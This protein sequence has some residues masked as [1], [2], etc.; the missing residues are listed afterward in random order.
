MSQIDNQSHGARTLRPNL[1]TARTSFV[2]RERELAE[3]AELLETARLVTLTGPAGCG[4]TR[5]AL[6]LARRLSGRFASGVHWLA[7]DS[8]NDPDLLVQTLAKS[9]GVG[10]RPDQPIL[11][12]VLQALQDRPLLLVLDNC[13]HL[14]PACADLVERLL[15]DTP[16]TVLATSRQPVGIDGE[17]LYPVNPLP[18][19]PANAPVEELARNDAVR[20]FT[21]RAQAIRPDFNLNASNA[22][23]VGAICRAVDG[24][25]LAIEL[26]SARIN[27]LTTEQIANRLDDHFALLPPAGTLT[28]SHHATLR[29][30]IDWSHTL[31][32]KPEQ[33]LLRRL[34]V[35]AGGW[36]LSAAEAICAEDGLD[37][38]QVLDL[39][40]ALVDR[41]LI[42]AN[43]LQPGEA[44]YRLLETVRQY[45]QEKLQAAAEW[46]DLK[47]RHLDHFLERTQEADQKVRGPYQPLWLNW[48][49]R[50]YANIRTALS[51]S[52]THD[53]I[54]AGLRLA[55]ALYQF[56]VVR[57]Y[58]VEGSSW[59][60]RLLAQA[61]DTVAVATR[62][63]ALSYANFLAGIRG[64]TA[65]QVAYGQEAV[66]VARAAG[67]QA[68]P[69]LAMALSAQGFGAR[70]Q[71]DYETEFALS[72]EI[73]QLRR[74]LGDPYQLGLA[75]SLYVVP[76]M[77]VG[78]YEVAE[79]MMAE[80]LPLLRQAGDP[81]RI[82]MALNYKGDLARCQ[83]DYPNARRAYEESLA[84][85]RDLDA[86]RDLASVMHNLGHT[87]L[88]LGQVE[89]ARTL[90]EHSLATHQAQQ[91]RNGL[92]ECLL[93]F[94]AL[95]VSK[96][97]PAVGTTLLA[98]AAAHGGRHVTDQWAAT[99][100]EYE[101]YLDR[102]RAA[103][104]ERRF[105]SARQAGQV[106][107]LDAAVAQ[108]QEL[109]R[110]LDAHRRARRQVDELTP[111]EREVAALVG[112]AKSND[113]IAAE[114]VLSKRTVETH[115]S[116][117]Y[118]KLGA[119][120]R[121]EI[122]RWALDSGLVKDD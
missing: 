17:R 83:G 81:Y 86:P 38:K 103:L 53:R 54:E 92:A 74:E 22:A 40:S 76:A 14:L 104:S 27:V 90:F 73:I 45:A 77:A 97:R 84:L 50:E 79:A 49:E 64:R 34:A 8:L 119:S 56:W 47:D 115:V 48:L 44:R 78:E 109:G 105:R 111:R 87:R 94:A 88:H 112:Q 91:N 31:L 110:A 37:Q 68:K 24:I 1:P 82:A 42:L 30:A 99:R 25:P 72:Q 59:L 122:V 96:D 69:A 9:L 15:T 100:L 98:A 75:L 67:P 65:A 20:L 23:Q 113:E 4:K 11:E 13:E 36:S 10:E 2:G 51:W 18:V 71:G 29:A 58:L 61:D 16:L 6:R 28:H 57:D 116:H 102:A 117:I 43:T 106:L 26:A 32:R 52:L 7:L 80:A 63:D 118:A 93:G 46:A 55:V 35:F 3:T 121:A 41:S 12:T 95:A 70:A 66:R 21:E 62:V 108:A 19:P 107:S 33:I 101:H 60:E 39:L 5:L 120:R 114:L 89:E 85:L